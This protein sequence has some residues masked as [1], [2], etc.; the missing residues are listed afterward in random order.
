MAVDGV[1]VRELL[2]SLNIPS[3][4]Y[5]RHRRDGLSHEQALEAAKQAE[6]RGPRNKALAVDQDSIS[7]VSRVLRQWKR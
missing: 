5:Y 1:N 6:V 2:K 7:D 3:S 4:A